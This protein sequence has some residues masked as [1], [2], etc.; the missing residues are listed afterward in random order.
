MGIRAKVLVVDDEVSIVEVLKG[1]FRRQGYRVKT[2]G[3]GEEALELLASEPF[4]L[5]LSDIRMSPIGGIELLRRAKE[6]QTHLAVIMMTAY[7]AVETAV[8][9]MR[10]G[11]FDYVCKPFKVDELLV[12]VERAL[13]YEAVLEENELLKET[14]ESPAEVHFGTLV[15]DH[16]L[17]QTVYRTIRKVAA[18]DST[19]LILGESGTGKELA[20]RAIHDCS[21]RKSRPLVAIN[22]AAM[23][24][25]LLESELFGHVRGAF[26]GANRDKKGLF[27]TADGGTL[28]LDEVGS[29]PM[30]M[31][32]TLLRVLQ[33]QK[34]RP[35]G[36]TRLIP[37]NVRIVAATNER[38]EDLIREGR[39]RE[40]LYY[41]L[42]VIPIEMPALRDRPSDV[43]LLT[44]H[45]LA[46]MARDEGVSYAVDAKVLASLE[47]YHWPGNV[48]ELEN[49][50]KRAAALCDNATITVDV[51]PEPLRRLAPRSDDG[52]AGSATAP[53]PGTGVTLKAFL[54][55]KE[56]AYI[57]QVLEQ[58]GGDKDAAAKA[59]GVSLAT[60]YR[61]YSES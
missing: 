34:I 30:A 18:T 14:I 43:P 60:L 11:A 22:C 21:P 12:T 61:K 51:L 38:L 39:F 48:R 3:S 47:G 5:M 8:E 41:R 16:P 25:T 19:V 53:A 37:V 2:A 50:L 32:S 26:T 58:H 17:M 20:A 23:P 31:Q 36:G 35:V 29:I 13:S 28:F 10:M 49:V 56:R 45:I 9:A 7:A 4:D 15:G 55:D 54:R 59:L 42:S 1:I 46:G 57:K 27:E 40:D 44:R 6:L 52:D 24:E 33:E